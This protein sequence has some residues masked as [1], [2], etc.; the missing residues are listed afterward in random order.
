[1]TDRLFTGHSM[2][3]LDCRALVHL[4]DL[5]FE[6]LS[7]TTVGTPHRG[8]P[9]ADTFDNNTLGKRPLLRPSYH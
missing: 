6:V 4:R 9:Y 5:E 7:I 1:M 2:G 3:G 8:S